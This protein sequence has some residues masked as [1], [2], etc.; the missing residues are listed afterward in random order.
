M[1]NQEFSPKAPKLDL[2]LI[3]FFL[4]AYLIG[5]GLIPVMSYL[6]QYSGEEGTKPP[7][8][9]NMIAHTGPLLLSTKLIVCTLKTA[10]GPQNTR[11][12]NPNVK[13]KNIVASLNWLVFF[14]LYP[15]IFL[16]AN[17]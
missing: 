16:C 3:L 12:D 1:N 13:P 11:N 9:N 5:W 14:I 8:T 17:G 2:P 4:I 15:M 7:R 6:A 10:I